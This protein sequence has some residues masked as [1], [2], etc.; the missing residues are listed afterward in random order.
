MKYKKENEIEYDDIVV[1]INNSDTPY[2]CSKLINW[3][4]LEEDCGPMFLAKVYDYQGNL[5]TRDLK[6]TINYICEDG[7]YNGPFDCSGK[8]IE[9]IEQELELNIKKQILG[10]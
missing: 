3:K 4:F 8:I 5:M 9:Q 6:M 1:G 10:S 7:K 2:H